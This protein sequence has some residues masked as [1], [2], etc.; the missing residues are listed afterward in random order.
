MMRIRN[1]LNNLLLLFATFLFINCSENRNYEGIALIDSYTVYQNGKYN[2]NLY[3]LEEYNKKKSLKENL[4]N[5]DLIRCYIIYIDKKQK[6]SIEYLKR[7]INKRLILSN[8]SID[9]LDDK[10]IIYSVKNDIIELENLKVK[11]DFY[12]IFQD[13][14]SFKINSIFNDGTNW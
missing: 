10:K 13:F 4:Q 5:Q 2:L 9:L 6:D 1:K 3:L 11:C 12:L 7:K 14:Q 8:I